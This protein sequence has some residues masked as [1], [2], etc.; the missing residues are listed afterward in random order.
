[1]SK[2]FHGDDRRDNHFWV[3]PKCKPISSRWDTH[4][5]ESYCNNHKF[6]HTFVGMNISEYVCLGHDINE[7]ILI[8]ILAKDKAACLP[9][10]LKC[11]YIF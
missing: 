3:Y 4:N 6:C 10:Y 5:L 8:A 9:F 7:D 2:F 11:I 1:M